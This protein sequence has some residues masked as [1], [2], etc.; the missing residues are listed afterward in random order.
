MSGCLP[1]LVPE[2]ACSLLP[3]ASLPPCLLPCPGAAHP[4]ARGVQGSIPGPA[5]QVRHWECS[6][7]PL[8]L[9]WPLACPH[10]ALA[11]PF[12]RAL[13]QQPPALG[14]LRCALQVPEGEGEKGTDV[15]QQA[16]LSQSLDKKEQRGTGEG[17]MAAHVSPRQ[18]L[19]S[20]ALGLGI[21]GYTGDCP[22][23]L[24]HSGLLWKYY[25]E[26]KSCRPGQSQL[27]PSL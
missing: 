17:S 18:A 5:Q 26:R 21:Q 20:P 12:L 14:W 24:S 8:C 27:S 13:F 9:L 15:W 22:S 2:P 16:N 1:L 25:P 3:V 11:A 23:T 6:Q 4:A 7:G 10:G 19:Q